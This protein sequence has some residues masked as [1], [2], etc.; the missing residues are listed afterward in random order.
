MISVRTSLITSLVVSLLYD[1]NGKKRWGMLKE[2]L[3]LST[4]SDIGSTY[5]I[6]L[7]LIAPC[8]HCGLIY[9]CCIGPVMYIHND[10]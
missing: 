1:V 4:L 9:E 10:R 6:G 3:Y 5:G 7:F 2:L 8:K